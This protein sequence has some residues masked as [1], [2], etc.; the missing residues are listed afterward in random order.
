MEGVLKTRSI[1]REHALLGRL[2]DSLIRCDHAWE[3]VSRLALF[4]AI[5]HGEAASRL[6]ICSD[7]A[8]RGMIFLDLVSFAAGVNSWLSNLLIGVYT[9]ES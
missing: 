9:A 8:Q 7:Q 3:A 1:R 6:A 5:M 2:C 4:A